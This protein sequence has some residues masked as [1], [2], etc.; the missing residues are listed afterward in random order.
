VLGESLDS[1]RDTPNMLLLNAAT[2]DLMNA[3]LLI[4]FYTRH[5]VYNPGSWLESLPGMALMRDSH[6]SA[7]AGS[8]TTDGIF[9]RAWGP[10]QV[11]ECGS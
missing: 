3:P 11:G 10:L 1:T 2:T 8:W 7:L 9:L 4:F 6:P 5:L